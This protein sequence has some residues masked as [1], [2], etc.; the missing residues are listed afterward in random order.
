MLTDSAVQPASQDTG[1]A[2]NEALAALDDVDRDVFLMREVAGLGYEEI[3]SACGLTPDAVRNRIYR[4]R[5][6]LR[7][8]ALGSDRGPARGA[9]A[10][11]GPAGVTTEQNGHEQHTRS[12]FGVSGR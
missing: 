1:A 8:S 7:D 12:H 10:A 5:L 6:Q 9:D 3:A 2:V 11:V 4:A